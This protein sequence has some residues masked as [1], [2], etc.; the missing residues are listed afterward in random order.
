MV[1][2]CSYYLKEWLA[3]RMGNL[4]ENCSHST[5]HRR[6]AKVKLSCIGF[7]PNYFDNIG[8]YDDILMGSNIYYFKN[9]IFKGV[10]HS[11]IACL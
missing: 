2:N 10:C 8:L 4:Y 5:G 7:F 3:D 1:A 11:S 6:S 9:C